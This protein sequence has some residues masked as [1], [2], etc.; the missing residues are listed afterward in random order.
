MLPTKDGTVGLTPTLHISMLYTFIII[1]IITHHSLISFLCIQ[2]KR[3]TG[4]RGIIYADL[5]QVHMYIHVCTC[6]CVC[7]CVILVEYTSTQC[8]Y[9]CNIGTV[10]K[11]KCTYMC[12]HV[13]TCVILVVYTSTH[14]HTCMYMYVHV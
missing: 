7:T 2:G 13:C 8:M 6:T 12:V 4:A 11:Y 10:Y 9:M 5:G 3:K 1:S 14:V